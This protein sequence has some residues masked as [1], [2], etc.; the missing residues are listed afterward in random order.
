MTVCVCVFFSF[1]DELALALEILQ[2]ILQLLWFG[3]ATVCDLLKK[4][5]A[6]F[7]SEVKPKPIVTCLHA[8]FRAWGRLHVFASSS[9]WFIALF[10][11]VVI[12]QS[13]NFGFG[14]TTLNRKPL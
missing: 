8:F 9:D 5:R 14:L 1:S 2:I 12:S 7:R 13:N 10:T 4:S 3:I 6:T 11:T